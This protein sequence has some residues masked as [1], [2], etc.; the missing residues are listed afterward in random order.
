MKFNWGFKIGAVYVA[1]VVMMIVL[2]G[3]SV[4]QKIDLVADDYYEQ[5]LKFE[6][7]IDKIRRANALVEKPGWR[8]EPEGI[9]ITFPGSTVNRNLTGE[10]RLYCPA[11]NT[12]DVSFPIE[13]DAAGVQLIPIENI[14]NGRYQLQLDW[15]KDGSTFW[16]EGVINI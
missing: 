5:E 3:M 15:A 4:G 1:F 8:V 12:K 10:I 13:P 7:R 16:N 14:K 6:E 2:V 9:R 11:D